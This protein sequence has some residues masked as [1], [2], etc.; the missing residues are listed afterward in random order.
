MAR[1][2][3]TELITKDTTTPTQQTPTPPP[4]APPKAQ[5]PKRRPSSSTQLK[6]ASTA[7][8][9]ATQA[10]ETGPKQRPSD[11]PEPEGIPGEKRITLPLWQTLWRALQLARVDDGIDTTIRIRS[12]IELWVHDDRIRARV[13]KLAKQRASTLSRGRPRRDR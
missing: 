13:D 8:Q 12:M 1:V 11:P 4:D 6:A 2:N 5:K 7:P 3:V 9:E 10:S